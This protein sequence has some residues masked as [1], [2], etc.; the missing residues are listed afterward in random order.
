MKVVF[1][2]LHP[3]I[4]R[5]ATGGQDG[6]V[7]I[8]NTQQKKKEKV[9]DLGDGWIENLSWSQ[10][11]EML[12]ISCSRTIYVYTK[13]GNE[14]WQSDSHNSTVS[15]LAW[16]IEKELATTCYG[17]V[18]F[19]DGISG[20]IKQKLEWKGSLVSMVLSPNSDI[21]VCGSQDNTIHFWRRSTEQDSMM[22]G[23]PLK[24]SALSF[25]ET[26][27]YLATGGK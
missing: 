14:M 7:I 19:F 10:D 27:S 16:S 12:A 15:N 1:F 13:E 26:G 6:K 20:K 8:W 21:V 23:Y 11:G 5:F 2:Q 17:R 3:L 18:S 22:S 4:D 25:D 9:I 24:P